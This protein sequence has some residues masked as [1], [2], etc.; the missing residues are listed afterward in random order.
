MTPEAL[1][2]AVRIRHVTRMP[3]PDGARIPQAVLDA[4]VV[5]ETMHTACGTGQDSPPWHNGGT[6][7]GSMVACEVCYRR[8]RWQDRDVW[9]DND[10]ARMTP[11][12]LRF[13]A[14]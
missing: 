5:A 3:R 9:R 13:L 10:H 2:H 8:T 11:R 12:G 6:R 14:L 1:V 7:G 4:L